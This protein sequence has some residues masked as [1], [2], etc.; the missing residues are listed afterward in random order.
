MRLN[1]NFHLTGIGNSAKCHLH[2]FSKMNHLNSQQLGGSDTRRG[3]SFFQSQPEIAATAQE[4]ANKTTR[5]FP[6][7]NVDTHVPMGIVI[8]G[9]PIFDSFPPE[10][11]NSRG[12]VD[13]DNLVPDSM[14]GL[15]PQITPVDLRNFLDEADTQPDLEVAT[16]TLPETRYLKQKAEAAMPVIDE[17]EI[18]LVLG[19]EIGPVGQILLRQLDSLS[20][21]Q[22][23]PLNTIELLDDVFG[24][25]PSIDD[26][27]SN[28]EQQLLSVIGEFF[29]KEVAQIEPEILVPD[30]EE[31]GH[32]KLNPIILHD[33]FKP[34]IA[35]D[36]LGYEIKNLKTEIKDIGINLD[37]L[38]ARTLSLT[39]QAGAD[40]EIEKL[41][42]QW[43]GLYGELSAK[44]AKLLNKKAE[45]ERFNEEAKK[46]SRPLSKFENEVEFNRVVYPSTAESL[47]E[48]L[49]EAKDSLPSMVESAKVF[50][51]SLP[52]LV[53][54]AFSAVGGFFSNLKLSNAKK[55]Y[56]EPI[57]NDEE[58]FEYRALGLESR[59]PLILNVRGKEAR[60]QLR[61]KYLAEIETRKSWNAQ[62]AANAV[63]QVA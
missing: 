40:E 51:K 14:T 28:L 52:S 10:Q 46:M 62:N 54:N 6:V 27:R 35:S 47:V 61:E 56:E 4:A 19:K 43:L 9:Q 48:T 30:I 63:R 32:K 31:D 39:K 21:I 36:R 20:V 57:L 26:Q 60:E 17:A 8:V 37:D 2:N 7:I 58:L 41:E 38:K 5:V 25:M 49:R 16:D 1:H 22:G 23:R 33:H 44:Q 11:L 12:L 13:P 29:E 42:S 59:H 50:V 45:L 15:F 55:P 53:K 24:P 34:K 3:S 18:P